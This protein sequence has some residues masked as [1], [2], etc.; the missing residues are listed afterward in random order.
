MLR[1]YFQQAFPYGA[2]DVFVAL[3]AHQRLTSHHIEADDHLG[4]DGYED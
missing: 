3:T 4:R 2:S 1:V